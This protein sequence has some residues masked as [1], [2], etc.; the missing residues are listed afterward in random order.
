MIPNEILYGAVTADFNDMRD[1][2]T[3]L[4][5]RLLAVDP[6]RQMEHY[7]II[8]NKIYEC[9]MDAED[10]GNILLYPEETSINLN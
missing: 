1:M 4:E 6:M 8:Q 3:E 7:K 5:Q 2:L 9:L 10:E